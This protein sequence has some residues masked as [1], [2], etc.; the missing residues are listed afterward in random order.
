MRTLLIGLGH[1]A[2]Q[3]KDS[4]A[5]FILEAYAGKLDVRRYSFAQALKREVNVAAEELCRSFDV[6]PE[7]AFRYLCRLFG[8]EYDPAPDMTDP[9]CPLGKQ[10][11]LLQRYGTEFRRAQDH[12]YWVNSLAATIES[13]APAVALITDMRFWNEA[14]WIQ[15][16][17]GY[18]VNVLRRGAEVLLATAAE[19]AHVSECELD[20]WM[21][22]Y[23]IVAGNGEMGVIQRDALAVFANILERRKRTPVIGFYRPAHAPAPCQEQPNQ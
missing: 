2:R 16:S 19:A 23:K 4:A 9:D 18:T 22:D 1:K 11:S 8:A 20:G 3:G 14:T 13:E 12:D 17:G 10:R 21:Y 5:R 6:K 7:D 15:E